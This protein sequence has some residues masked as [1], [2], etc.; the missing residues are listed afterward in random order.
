MKNAF[1][2][3][4]SLFLVNQFFPF[5]SSLTFPLLSLE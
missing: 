5:P 4:H 3:E 1:S 2:K